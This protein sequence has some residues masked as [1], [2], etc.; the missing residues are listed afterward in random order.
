MA[1]FRQHNGI[2]T[3]VD[4]RRLKVRTWTDGK[5]AAC[6]GCKLASACSSNGGDGAP[7]LNAV[8]ASGYDAR[9]GDSVSLIPRRRPWVTVLRW[10]IAPAAI[11]ALSILYPQVMVLPL[12]LYL[13][14]ERRYIAEKTTERKYKNRGNGLVMGQ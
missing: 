4:G 6:S 2:V 9:V 11:T 14:P 8:A 3:E 5:Q 7:V 10:L 12:L 13:I 1:G